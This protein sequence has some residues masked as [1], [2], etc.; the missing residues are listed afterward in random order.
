VRLVR[1]AEDGRVVVAGTVP[2]RC[3]GELA[4]SDRAPVVA[5]FSGDGIDLWD[6]GSNETRR[7]EEQAAF[8]LSP[9]GT[10]VVAWSGRDVAVYPAWEDA[11][12]A[13]AVLHE[14]VRLAAFSPR[15]GVIALGTGKR[16]FV[17]DGDDPSRKLWEA[18][19]PDD[20]VALVWDQGGLDLGACKLGGAVDWIHLRQG[21]RAASDEPEGRCDR[22]APSAPESATSRFD[23]GKLGMRDFGEHF[24]RGA[25][26]LTD[27]RWLSPTLVLSSSKDDALE[28]V[29]TFA[30]RDDEGARLP[31]SADDGLS[32]VLRVADVV[33][34]QKARNAGRVERH[35]PA[36][37]VLLHAKNGKRVSST[38]GFLLGAC[39][40]DRILYFRPTTE[41]LEIR[42]LRLNAEVARIPREPG[43]VVGVSPG[44]SKLYV[45]RVDGTLVAH[46]LGG[47]PA[48]NVIGPL[49][50][51]V[52]DVEPTVGA[53]PGGAGLIAALSNG[54]IVAIGQGTDT[55]R[56]V[57][58][59]KPRATALADGIDAGEVLYADA[60]GVYRVDA[61]GGSRSIAPPRSGAA[62]EDLFVTKDRRAVL[63]A[64]AAEIGVIDLGSSSV[65]ATVSV[66]GMTRFAAWDEQGSVLAYAPDLD[67]VAHG[68]LIPFGPGTVDAIGSLASNLRVDESGNLILKQ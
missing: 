53:A 57:A 13:R 11:P 23:L 2:L 34:I 54:D 48:S 65:A 62:W 45:Q 10:R 21:P 16:V 38:K 31:V 7:I 40:D 18:E 56:T 39:P 6:M 25:F 52:Y 67:G 49:G 15:D 59:A 4:A 22:G 26:R 47:P 42:E 14:D 63:V 5:C 28:R 30:E 36:D 19:T 32:R 55:L 17:V 35:E 46:S 60:T 24:S 44:C 3:R 68:I 66:A 58:S 51:Y 43:F 41:T 27:E 37:L 9:D 20:A 8:A 61:A 64:S 12:P 50:G 29:L 33:A 1:F